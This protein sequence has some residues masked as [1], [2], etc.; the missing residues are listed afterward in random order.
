MP[1]L[2]SEIIILPLREKIHHPFIIRQIE[3]PLATKEDF[4]YTPDTGGSTS[5]DLGASGALFSTTWLAPQRLPL[6]SRPG[7]RPPSTRRCALICHVPVVVVCFAGS[8]LPGQAVV[9]QVIDSKAD[10]VLLPAE[11]CRFM[12]RRRSSA[13]TTLALSQIIT[14][15]VF[16]CPAR[17]V[18]FRVASDACGIPSSAGDSTTTLRLHP[19]ITAPARARTSSSSR[20]PARSALPIQTGLCQ[21]S[22]SRRGNY[23]TMR[24]GTPMLVAAVGAA[25]L[26]LHPLR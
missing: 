16:G 26:C 14:S 21:L 15:A 5:S 20:W 23:R 13:L 4:F 18:R 9:L 11:N 6:P 17:S 1:C 2:G 22:P 19:G 25:C 8:L 7:C 12:A 3:L 10:K 24:T